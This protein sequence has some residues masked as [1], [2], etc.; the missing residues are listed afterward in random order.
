M[1][2]TSWTWLIA[3][4]EES[5]SAGRMLRQIAV[6][7]GGTGA[8][9][10]LPPAHRL[11]E[12]F[13]GGQPVIAD[14]GQ[15][16]NPG[17]VLLWMA[18]LT[19]LA[20]QLSRPWISLSSGLEDATAAAMVQALS[21]GCDHPVERET[22][23]DLPVDKTITV[24]SFGY[25]G[26][27]IVWSP[28]LPGPGLAVRDA[29]SHVSRSAPA[30]P[31]LPAHLVTQCQVTLETS[32]SFLAPD[33]LN[34]WSRD[35]L[36]RAAARACVQDLPELE[37]PLRCSIVVAASLSDQPE[38]ALIQLADNLLRDAS[39]LDLCGRHGRTAPQDINAALQA[40]I[41][42]PEVLG[43]ELSLTVLGNLARWLQRTAPQQLKAS[44]L[45][46]SRRQSAMRT[47]ARLFDAVRTG[48]AARTSNI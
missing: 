12:A 9:A 17:S 40:V 18:D 35:P 29:L 30:A 48:L 10:E 19:D 24:P 3:R 26:G 39:A 11:R 7:L 22:I 38:S 28:Q 8:R 5:A 27:C 15:F 20:P 41:R 21:G 13:L 47:D 1:H 36:L 32:G 34:R 45:M 2:L 23:P 16:D 43:T 6:T 37:V 4:E 25:D 31:A 44:V 14:A 46:N 33:T 42:H